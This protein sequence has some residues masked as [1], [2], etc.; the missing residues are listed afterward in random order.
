MSDNVKGKG[1]LKVIFLDID[2]VLNDHA[3]NVAGYCG[4]KPSCVEQLNRILA[5]VPDAHIVV[6]SAW[7]Y[8]VHGKDMTIKG[9]E[10]LL[11][12]GGVNCNGLVLGVTETDEA[13]RSRGGQ[14]DHAITKLAAV[15][16]FAI[17]DD[18]LWDFNE[19]GLF[20]RLVKTDPGV[21]LTESEANRAIE[22]LNKPMTL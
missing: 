15:T 13:I 9:F 21:G 11:M 8:I 18:M 20:R 22:M 16:S 12:V 3:Q 14:I 5:A 7:R 6:S 19:R 1:L 17:L 4:L 10:Y 2:G